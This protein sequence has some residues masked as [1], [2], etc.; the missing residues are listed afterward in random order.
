[1]KIVLDTNVFI[2]SFFWGGNPRKIME[3][4]IAGKDKLFICE[5]IIQETALVLSRPKFNVSNEYITRY[6]RSIEELAY[7]IALTGIVQNICRDSDDD[8][9]LECALLAN[10]DYIIT[11]DSDLLILEEFRGTKIVTANDYLIENEDK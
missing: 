7:H 3:R 9:I 2:S 11:G 8:K 5:E 4:I 1:M 10:A 6:I